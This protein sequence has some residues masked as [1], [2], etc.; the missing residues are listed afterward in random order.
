MPNKKIVGEKEG[1][2]AEPR[3]VTPGNKREQRDCVHLWREK[4][5]AAE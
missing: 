1:R 5:S 2:S 3:K 4:S